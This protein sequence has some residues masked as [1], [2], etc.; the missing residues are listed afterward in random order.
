MELVMSGIGKTLYVTEKRICP[1]CGEKINTLAIRKNEKNELIHYACPM[2]PPEETGSPA[3]ANGLNGKDGDQKF[4][5]EG[6]P[7]GA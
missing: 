6:T 1:A 2:P 3:S 5:D 4:H 7:A